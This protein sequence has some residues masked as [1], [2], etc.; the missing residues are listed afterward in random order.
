MKTRDRILRTALTLFNEEGEADQTAVDLANVLE[1]SPGNLYY[2]FKGKDAIIKVLFDN[3]E[4]EMRMILG[5]SDGAISNMEDQWVFTYILLEEIYDF[6]FFYRDIG[7]LLARYPELAVRFRG[8]LKEK[9]KTIERLLD[10]LSSNEIIHIDPV[11]T[12]LLSDQILATLTYW[13]SLDQIEGANLPPA[14]LIHRTV[15]QTM[16]MIV[17]YM[18]DD[19]SDMLQQMLAHYEQAI[20]T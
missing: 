7:V 14:H 1:I 10:H 18:G 17:P 6:R 15:F 8:L 19:G 4:T 16:A 12:S 2:H 11:L 20:A 3:F 9:R 5:G 13:L